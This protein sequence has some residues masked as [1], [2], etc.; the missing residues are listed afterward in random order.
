MNQIKYFSRDVLLAILASF[1]VL[2]AN[3][4]YLDLNWRLSWFLATSEDYRGRFILGLLLCIVLCLTIGVWIGRTIKRE[5]PFSLTLMLGVFAATAIASLAADL[6]AWP[7]HWEG[8]MDV[9]RSEVAAGMLIYFH[10]LAII[11]VVWTVRNVERIYARTT[12]RSGAS[13]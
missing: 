1:I 12:F 7:I 10:P 6:I 4:I 8:M 9:N 3:N 2:K 5:A 13:T 11:L